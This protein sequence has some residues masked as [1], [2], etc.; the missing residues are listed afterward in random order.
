MPTPRRAET[1]A[2]INNSPSA[3]VNFARL[4][5][6]EGRLRIESE[7]P[8]GGFLPVRRRQTGS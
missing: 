6:A 5:P 1:R 3:S 8:Q 2:N 7:N 4:L